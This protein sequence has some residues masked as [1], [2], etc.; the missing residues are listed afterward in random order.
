M[1]RVDGDGVDVIGVCVGVDFTGNSSNNVVLLLHA[2]QLEL[3]LMGWWRYGSLA[4][5]EVG[6]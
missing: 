2:R 1:V 3:R 5:C 6:L 4:F